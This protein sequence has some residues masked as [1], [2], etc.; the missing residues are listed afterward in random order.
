MRPSIF[1]HALNG[2]LLL[3]AAVLFLQNYKSISQETMIEFA[4]LFSIA[5]GIHAIL[6]HY[7]EI[8]Y[9]FNPLDKKWKVYDNAVLNVKTVN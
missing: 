2:F 4:L 1:G 3:I 6:H 9:N 8:Y 5:F 7:E